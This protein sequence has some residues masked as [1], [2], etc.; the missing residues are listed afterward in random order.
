MSQTT[1]TAPTA[2]ALTTEMR[3]HLQCDHDPTAYKPIGDW[4]TDPGHLVHH[5]I[6]LARAATRD[7]GAYGCGRHVEE[8]D[9]TSYRLEKA[10]LE[11]GIWYLI[12]ADDQIA[13]RLELAAK[14]T[15]GKPSVWH[16]YDR[17]ELPAAGAEK[18]A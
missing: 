13:F 8:R 1:K 16:V 10:E 12:D 2:A 17:R 14:A 7:A 3:V 5:E 9:G 18:E 4:T 6:R 11:F 15:R